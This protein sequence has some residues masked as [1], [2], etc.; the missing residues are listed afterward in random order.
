VAIALYQ[1]S[2]VVTPIFGTIASKFN[3]V[4]IQT[5][6]LFLWLLLQQIKLLI[7]IIIVQFM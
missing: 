6:L 5:I 3:L 4:G 7:I 1:D 2:A